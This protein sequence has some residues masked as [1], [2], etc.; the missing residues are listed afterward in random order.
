MATGRVRFDNDDVTGAARACQKVGNSRANNA[1][2]DDKGVRCWFAPEDMKIGAPIL[3]EIDRAIRL[4]DKLLLVLSN[5]SLQS[6]W[7]EH[8]FLSAEN[9]EVH[10]KSKILFPVRIDNAV[11][12]AVA[13]VRLRMLW[14]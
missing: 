9:Q 12:E 13:N 5:N 8:E 14:R 2:A 1:A 6:E 3:S 10:R 7:V 4:H 11:M